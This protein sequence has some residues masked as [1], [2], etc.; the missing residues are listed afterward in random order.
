MSKLRERLTIAACNYYGPSL[1]HEAFEEDVEHYASIMQA[2][3]YSEDAVRRI[4][5]AAHDEVAE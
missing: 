2:C 4:V 5:R 3:G 1:G